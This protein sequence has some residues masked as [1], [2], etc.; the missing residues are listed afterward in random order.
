MK[1]QDKSKS[2]LNNC[3]PKTQSV[4]CIHG[5]LKAKIPVLSPG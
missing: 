3:I 2:T 1:D 5:L 4:V